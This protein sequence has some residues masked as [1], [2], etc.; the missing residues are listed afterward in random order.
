MSTL[1]PNAE[2]TGTTETPNLVKRVVMVFISP[3][4][5]GE[6]LRNRSPW[7]WTL[8]PL[9]VIGLI[10]FLLIPTDLILQAA[11]QGMAR[12]GGGTPPPPETIAR[13]SRIF[14][15]VGALVS[16]I[17]GCVVVA[18]VLYFVFNVLFGQDERYAQHLSAAAHA[19][20]IVT[21]GAVVTL[22]LMIARGDMNTQLSLGLLVQEPT[23]SFIG[24]FLNAIN[25][26]GLWGTVA[27]G[28][29]ESGLSGGRVSAGKAITAVIG[30]YLVWA[31]IIAAFRSVSG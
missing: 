21:L 30:L 15:T 22:P 5:L 27:L 17:I 12:R 24:R 19:F 7:F 8:V 31:L 1:E 26:F 16:P 10:V 11:Q 13:M 29:V 4:R 25:I 18:A 2:A 3:A 20:W 14:G 28:M 9:A 23:V 6:A